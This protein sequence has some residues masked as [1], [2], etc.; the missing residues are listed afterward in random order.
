M[1]E[2]LLRK[3]FLT[4]EVY[5]QNNIVQF[6]RWRIF[7]CPLFSI[8]IH[9]LYHGDPVPH[10][11]NHPFNFLCLVLFGHFSEEINK[12]T[13]YPYHR[14]FGE[15]YKIKL[16]DFHRIKEVH[17]K[18]A[19]LILTGPKKKSTWEYKVNKKLID[20]TVYNNQQK[21]K[22]EYGTT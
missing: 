5:I 11:H 10:L 13:K 3:F 16:K 8:Y 14:F 12:K 19:L 6:Q 15:F 18:S 20:Y 4:K 2:K 21:L 7:S 9:I 1:F 17:K 22:K